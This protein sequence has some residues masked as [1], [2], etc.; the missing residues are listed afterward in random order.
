LLRTAFLLAA[1]RPWSR[2]CRRS[3]AAWGSGAPLRRD[4]LAAVS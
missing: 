2:P 4:N 3:S 1:A